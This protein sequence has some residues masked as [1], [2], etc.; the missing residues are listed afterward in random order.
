MAESR[1][2]G[3]DSEP[4]AKMTL[5]VY[6]VSAGGD[7]TEDRGTLS[8]LGGQEPPPTTAAFPPCKCPR[9]KGQGAKR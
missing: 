2:L 1:A 7:V 9:H 6:R 3:Q 8:I 5:R 4:G